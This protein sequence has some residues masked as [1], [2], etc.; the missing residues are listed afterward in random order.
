[1][2][3]VY[4]IVDCLKERNYSSFH[5]GIAKIPL[6]PRAGPVAHGPSGSVTQREA[7]PRSDGPRPVS[8]LKPSPLTR[9][10]SASLSP[11][12]PQNKIR[13]APARSALALLG[14][15]PSQ[16]ARPP[17]SSSSRKFPKPFQSLLPVHGCS[18][19]APVVLRS[20]PRVQS[21]PA[22]EDQIR[23]GFA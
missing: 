13:S 20:A 9:P 22:P 1:M 4:G 7:N 11:L 16:S 2:E 5:E 10:S 14:P 8:P 3:K 17:G 6:N 18:A 21:C 12:P 23:L 15:S 19:P